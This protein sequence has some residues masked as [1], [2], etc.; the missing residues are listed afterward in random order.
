MARLSNTEQAQQGIA[1][2]WAHFCRE[3]ALVR[4]RTNL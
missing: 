3:C 1:R 2:Q 4:R